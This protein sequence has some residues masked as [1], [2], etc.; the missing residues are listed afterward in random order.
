MIKSFL[1]YKGFEPISS[2]YIKDELNP[3]IWD[4]EKIDQEIREKLLSIATDFFNS[5]NIEIEVRDV[6]LCG[7]LANYNWS[8]RYSDYDL[9]IIVDLYDISEDYSLAGLVA[10]LSKKV[11]NTQH[12]IKIAGYEVEVGIQDY[13]DLAESIELGK[14]GGV[15]SLTNNKWIK[16]PIKKDFIPDE[17]LIKSKAQTVMDLVDDLEVDAE[18][19]SWDLFKEKI[20]RVWEKIKDFRKSGLSSE[21]GEFSIGNLV[22]K[23]LRRNGYINTVVNLKRKMYDEQFESAT[24]NDVMR[25]LYLLTRLMDKADRFNEGSY[26]INISFD[27]NNDKN[28]ISISMLEIM[29]GELPYTTIMEVLFDDSKILYTELEDGMIEKEK[30]ITYRDA[31]HL[32]S[33]IKSKFDV[34]EQ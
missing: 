11:W 7:S 20:D 8:E 15:F 9:H 33:I 29:K 13:R 25:I 5:T 19:D 31:E 2:F 22:F 24:P 27:Y 17:D 12:N 32:V 34:D 26:M 30:E 28:C 4:S 14:M 1:E 6:I 18:N 21:S 23:L 16:K 10:N 3:K